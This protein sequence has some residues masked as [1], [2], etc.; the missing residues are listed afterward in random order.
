MDS[1]IMIPG[2]GTQPM[3]DIYEIKVLLCYLLSSVSKPLSRKQL[4]EVF[5]EGSTVNYFSFCQAIEDMQKTG[6]ISTDKLEYDELYILQEHG[7]ETARLLEHT[8]P[9]SL[10]DNV[11]EIALSL[12]A[13]LKKESE[14]EVII[15]QYKNG[16][17]VRCIMHEVDFDIMSFDLFVPDIMQAEK[18]REKFLGNPPQL[19]R[20]MIQLLLDT[21][22]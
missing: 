15:S 2:I 11:V 4:Q 19:Y 8:L 20:N 16:Y 7:A 3:S 21:A 10:K 14:N 9:R 6:H 1:D 12:L 13:K 18:I 17:N 5:A 22:L